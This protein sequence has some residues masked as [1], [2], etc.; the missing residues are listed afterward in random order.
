M[1]ED[2]EKLRLAYELSKISL[3]EDLNVIMKK[4]LDLVFSVL[5]A[6]ERGIVLLYSEEND[7]FVINSIKYRNQNSQHDKIAVSMTILRMVVDRRS[8]FITTD[9]LQDPSV[10]SAQSLAGSN[11]RSVIAVPLISHDRVSLLGP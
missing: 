11:I 2:Y 10:L 9:A 7:G 6:I 5:P 1:R 8:C 3:S 4:L